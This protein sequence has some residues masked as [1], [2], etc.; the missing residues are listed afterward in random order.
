MFGRLVGAALATALAVPGAAPPPPSPEAL[1]AVEHMKHSH[2][3]PI[4]YLGTQ[5]QGM[6]LVYAEDDVPAGFLYADCTE[7]DL[8][9]YSL[10]CHHDVVVYDWP[11]IPGEISTQGRCTFSTT[12]RGAT[13]ALFPVSPH[14]L[15]VF[16]RGTTIWIG[17][18]SRR[19]A[20][21]AA[22]AL[23]G[24]NV[25]VEPGQRF[26]HRDVHAALGRCRP[27]KP[28][29]PPTPKQ[30]YER[31]MRD[32]WT[33]QSASTI[34]LAGLDPAAADPDAIAKEFLEEVGT[35]PLLLRNEAKRIELITPP[36]A[37]GDLQTQLVAELRAYADDIDPMLELVRQGA[38]RDRQAFQPQR[39]AFEAA[40]KQHSEQL[41]AIVDAFKALG[42]KI[43]SPPPD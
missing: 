12:I 41:L 21:A 24:L 38:W 2:A 22:R 35:F 11:P 1:A 7:V 43:V 16:T 6:S 37:V 27:P 32:S 23:R 25:K 15:H 42:Y 10:D 34:S 28:A 13:A 39:D 3:L 29:P 33:I 40:S 26:P 8:E 18:D 14:T 17:S 19:T 9:T 36:A 4:Y 20:L 31:R 30:R 5:Y